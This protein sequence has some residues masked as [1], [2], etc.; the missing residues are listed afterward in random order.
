M[1]MS[2]EMPGLDPNGNERTP[3]PL[4]ESRADEDVKLTV[5]Q[6]QDEQLHLG[7]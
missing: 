2:V 7:Y 5:A 3:C 1:W 4:W 6:R